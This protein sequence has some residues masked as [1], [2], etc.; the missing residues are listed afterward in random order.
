MKWLLSFT[1]GAG[2]LS[3]GC[4]SSTILSDTPQPTYWFSTNTSYR[5]FLDEC[6]GESVRFLF[7]DG[8]SQDGVLLEATPYSMVWLG[9]DDSIVYCQPTDKIACVSGGHPLFSVIMSSATGV[10]FIGAIGM[11]VSL[12]TGESGGAHPVSPTWWPACAFGA[13]GAVVGYLVGRANRWHEYQ[14][15]RDSIQPGHGAGSRRSGAVP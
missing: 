2:L 13:G 9:E 1:L 15:Q 14:V 12:S 5:A 10:I 8:R 6:R 3:C 11:M 7:R 4:S